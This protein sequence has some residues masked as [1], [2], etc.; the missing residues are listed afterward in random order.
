MTHFTGPLRRIGL[1][2]NPVS[3][4]GRSEAAAAQL[5]GILAD[6][7][8]I[9]L[10]ITAHSAAEARSRTWDAVRSGAIDALVV[11]GGDGTANIG[12]NACAATDIPLV[13]LPAGTGND[14]ARSLGMPRKDIPAIARLISDG[15][16]RR[17]D[18]GR[19]VTTDDERWWLGV[20][21]GGFDTL[22]NTRGRSLTALHGTP[23]Y[24]AAVA[25]E[26]PR[27]TGIP[28]LV[29]V[30]DQHIETEA[31][32]VAVANGGTFG[33]GMKVCPDASMTD[34]LFDVM[35]LHKIGRGEFLKIFP[36]VFSGGHVTHP[37][38]EILR[39]R[40][41]HLEADGI[42]SQADGEDFLPLPVDLEVVPGALAVVA[43]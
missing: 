5:R 34:G 39:G 11:V 38:V 10:D 7:G 17:V 29:Q 12:V 1:Y 28:Y 19:S 37:A 24:L 27:F 42:D 26:L 15:R 22:V 33:G 4:R 16:I 20:L 41:V 3:G 40:R 2:A 23:R 30:D 36:K 43:P 32:L 9:V 18:A 35:I 31:M 6:S 13:L 21:G 25:L 8:H 14:N